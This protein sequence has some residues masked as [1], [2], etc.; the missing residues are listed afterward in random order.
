MSGCSLT[1]DA[2]TSRNQ[3]ANAR[4]SHSYSCA[5]VVGRPH[6][7]LHRFVAGRPPPETC[8]PLCAANRAQMIATRYPEPGSG[9]RSGK[10]VAR[11]APCRSC[12]VAGASWYTA[13]MPANAP[14][15]EVLHLLSIVGSVLAQRTFPEDSAES[16]GK[17]L[18]NWWRPRV[19][20]LQA[21]RLRPERLSRTVQQA[22]RSFDRRSFPHQPAG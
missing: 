6:G 11:T 3:P 1:K 16:C 2:R 18:S 22:P 12:G 5:G 4:L 17:A 9:E 13:P 20:P 14:A 8:G 19:A 7:L 15:A 21:S 10:V